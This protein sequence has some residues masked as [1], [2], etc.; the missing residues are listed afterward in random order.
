M[1]FP[2]L[3]IPLATVLAGLVDF[4]IAFV[5]LLV[6]MLVHT[7]S[8]PA[9]RCSSSSRC[10]LLA[11]VTALGVG[12]WLAALNVQYRD[13]RYV[14]PFLTQ[15]W[16]FATPIAYPSSLVPRDVAPGVRAQPD[17]RRRRRVPLG[18]A[19]ERRHRAPTVAVSA[20]AARRA[21]LRVARCISGGWSGRSPTW[22]E[23]TT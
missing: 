18:A 22:S 6:V 23:G 2:R 3:A 19:R 9:S 17:G 10:V 8:C 5:L 14:L 12:L 16:L 21:R 20:L 7:G 1:Y 15:L 13:V 11:L 4:A